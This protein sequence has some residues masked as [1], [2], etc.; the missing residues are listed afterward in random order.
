MRQIVTRLTPLSGV[1]AMIERDVRAAAPRACAVAEAVGCILAKD[2][3]AATRPERPLALR[4]GWALRA[5]E[6]QGASAY[7]P[8]F[9]PVAP[10]PIETGQPMPEGCDCVALI[11]DVRVTGNAAEVVAAFA[12][13]EG[14]LAT[15]GD[16]DGRMPLMHAGARLTATSAAALAVFGITNVQ[17]RAPRVLVAFAKTDS[18][19]E[20][21]ADLIRRDLKN[22]GCEL[23]PATDVGA[24]LSHADADFVVLIGG[25]GSGGNDASVTALAQKGSVGVHGIALSPGETSA[26]GFLGNRPVLLLPGRVDATVA[27]WLMLGRLIVAR[28]CGAR[29]RTDPP[30][31]LTL[32]RK[33]ASTLGVTEVVPARCAG[34]QAEPLAAGYW[35]LSAIARADGYVVIAPESEGSSAGTAVQVWPLP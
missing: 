16:H 7:A 20:A 4:D 18:I 28:L 27:G 3:S 23:E 14:V 34:D 35:P 22:H 21:A 32:A 25:T 12:P 29:E 19:L 5:D 2:V 33:I 17:V 9:L 31:M 13:G 11:D 10:Q 26:L 30:R 8:A 6:T 1:R 15:G 24:A